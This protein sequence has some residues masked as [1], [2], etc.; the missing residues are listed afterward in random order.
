M[1]TNNPNTSPLT[2]TEPYSLGRQAQIMALVAAFLGWMFDGLE[3]G[4]FPLVARPALL[5]LL[6]A[7]PDLNIAGQCRL[8]A[9]CRGGFGDGTI[10]RLGRQCPELAGH[11]E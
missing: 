8:F 2:A 7:A 10:H 1:S 9:D 5:Q 11:V 6:G 3:M 4:L